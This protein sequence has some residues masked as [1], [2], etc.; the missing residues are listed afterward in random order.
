MA[1]VDTH[2]SPEQLL[3]SL[4]RQRTFKL[5]AVVMGLITTLVVG[6]VAVVLMYGS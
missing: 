5:I 1:I 6:S 4:R 3:A 2:E